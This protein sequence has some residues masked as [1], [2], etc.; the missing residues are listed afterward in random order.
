MTAESNHSPLVLV[1]DDEVPTTIMLQRIFEREGY[2][3]ESVNDG[4]SALEAAQKLLPD[5][6]LLDIQMPRCDGFAVVRD[7]LPHDAHRRA[8]TLTEA[9]VRGN[10]NESV[11]DREPRRHPLRPTDR[12]LP[13]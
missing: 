11:G 8:R 13:K 3:V 5:L 12:Q 9:A 6:I 10:G 7:C 1:A 4:V 2:A